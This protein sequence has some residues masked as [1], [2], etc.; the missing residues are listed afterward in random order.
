MPTF[1]VNPLFLVKL[2]ALITVPCRAVMGLI[3]TLLGISI[4]LSL[5]LTLPVPPQSNRAW[6]LVGCIFIARSIMSF[7]CSF[8]G[9]VH[10]NPFSPLPPADHASPASAATFTST[11]GF[12]S[13]SGNSKMS[14]KNHVHSGP[15]S[16]STLKT[17]TKSQP[18]TISTNGPSP[19]T[20]RSSRTS[21]QIQM[22]PT[23]K[24]HR[25]PHQPRR[26]PRTRHASTRLSSYRSTPPG[27]GSTD[28][29]CS[30]LTRSCAIQPSS[31]RS[32]LDFR[33]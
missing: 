2:S 24:L 21:A 29:Q 18:L 25:R 30:D 20:T 5:I 4:S 16:S 9:Y 10:S 26:R 6:R 12:S 8:R 27:T 32:V 14:T 3:Y 17:T 13:E 11:T 31:I 33:C 22:I 28:L 15:N 1:L 19:P 23:S 7:Y